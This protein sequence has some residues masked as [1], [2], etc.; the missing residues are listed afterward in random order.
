MTKQTLT[1]LLCVILCTTLG[2]IIGISTVSD[3]ETWYA[4]IQKPS[5]NPPNWIFGPVWTTLY[6]LMG[7]AFALV[8]N[9]PASPHRNR[10]IT[11]F[12][13]QFILNLAWSPIFFKLHNL[14]W[15]LIEIICM[16]VAII[17]TMFAFSRVHKT[18]PYLLLPYI[19][20]VSFAT[21]LT[22]T[23]YSLNP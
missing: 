20:W 14:L 5:W 17:L 23:I 4:T 11:L 8:I 21:L 7:I 1:I 12:I 3:I 10:A 13:I 19:A 22:A 6:A 9:S 18:A 2:A 15:A 16:W